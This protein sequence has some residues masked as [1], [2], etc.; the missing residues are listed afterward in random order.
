M[1]DQTGVSLSPRGRKREIGPSP[2]ESLTLS[3]SPLPAISK[4]SLRS[5]G[6]ARSSGTPSGPTPPAGSSPEPHATTPTAVMAASSAART[7][8]EARCERQAARTEEEEEEEEKE[9]EK[10][11]YVMSESSLLRSG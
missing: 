1:G 8:R 10:V 9:E 4:Q 6:A 5:V 3:G 2:V 11:E 7:W